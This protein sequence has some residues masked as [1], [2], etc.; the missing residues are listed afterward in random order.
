MIE[1]IRIAGHSMTRKFP[2]HTLYL[3]SESHL[4][5]ALYSLYSDTGHDALSGEDEDE[6]DIST[7]RRFTDLPLPHKS[8]D[9]LWESLVFQD[10]IGELI[11]RTIVRATRERLYDHHIDWSAR[12]WQNTVLLHG[13]PGS[14][15][16]TLAQ[17]LAQRLAIRLSNVYP[18][19]RLLEIKSRALLSRYFGES[20]KEIG[21]LF[22]SILRMADND[23]Q[24][25][26]VLIDEVESIAGCR[27]KAS[28]ASEVGDAIRVSR[29]S[30]TYICILKTARVY[31][32]SPTRVRQAQRAWEH[33][34]LLYD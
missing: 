13:P 26:V 31:K 33:C 10:P 15:K 20:S 19:S 5:I 7:L 4:D 32:R 34:V 25:V 18:T 1:W 28:R 17:A 21:E 16:T 24:L 3:L 8:F 14:G 27:T 11:L 12:S 22:E 2:D 6:S 23:E 9:G 30:F 29:I